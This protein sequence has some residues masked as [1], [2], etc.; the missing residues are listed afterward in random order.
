MTTDEYQDAV[1]AAGHAV[2]TAYG[3]FLDACN[4]L[5]EMLEFT[6]EWVLGKC[7]PKVAYDRERRTRTVWLNTELPDIIEKFK[8]S[9]AERENRA[10]RK[11]LLKSLNLT[12]EQKALLGIGE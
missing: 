3:D 9:V 2:D 4:A 8:Q 10:K 11:E 5:A 1:L 7:L 12:D 6:P